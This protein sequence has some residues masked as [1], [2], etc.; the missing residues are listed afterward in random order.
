MSTV[1]IT[2]RVTAIV[3]LIAR[4]PQGVAGPGGYTNLSFSRDGTSFTVASDTGDDAVILAATTSLAGAMTATDKTK[5]DAITGT[6]TGD[7]DLSGYAPLSSPA[8]TGTPTVP[9]A[10]P[11]SSTTQAANT[12]FV[13]A[14]IASLVASSPSALDTLNELAAALGNDANFSTTV[15][16][17][18]ALK[19]PLAS[20]VLTGTPI[21]PTATLGTYTTQI[22]TTEYVIN[23]VSATAA[24]LASAINSLSSSVF[25]TISALTFSGTVALDFSDARQ[26][27]TLA[28]TSD[29]AFTGSN[30]TAG[31]SMVIDITAGASPWTFAP[32]ATWKQR[33]SAAL[34]VAVGKGATLAIECWGTTEASVRFA[35]SHQ[36]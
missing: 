2:R 28:P 27:R 22:A 9:T 6:N 19:A 29:W 35:I 20:P 24:T 31:S 15:V 13:A 21:A 30:Y 33:G 11:G 12:A 7:Q 4:G 14:A 23:Q 10:S 18:L 17:A 8:L 5:L 1:I 26:M 32:P 36:P 34:T 3:Q 16:N 25:P